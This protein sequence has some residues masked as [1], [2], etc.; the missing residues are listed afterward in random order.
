[1]QVSKEFHAKI[2]YL[3]DAVKIGI[4]NLNNNFTNIITRYFNQ[5][6]KIKDLT[7]QLADKEKLQYSYEALREEYYLLL[8]A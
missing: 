3:S 8:Q 1:M 5:V 7:N 2:L 6:Q 4:L